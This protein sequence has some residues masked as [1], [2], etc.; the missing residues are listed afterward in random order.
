MP[1][2]NKKMQVF[3]YVSRQARKMELYMSFLLMT[4]RSSMTL[5]LHRTQQVFWH[6][7][8]RMTSVTTTKVMNPM[9]ERRIA[10]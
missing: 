8:T 7:F 1:D 10:T 2:T 4:S 5:F 9:K 6:Y 3:R